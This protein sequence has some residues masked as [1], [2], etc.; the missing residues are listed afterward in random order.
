MLSMR[1]ASVWE[2]WH[3]APVAAVAQLRICAA[4][5]R[6]PASAP[7]PV[8]AQPFCPTLQRCVGHNAALCGALWTVLRASRILALLPAP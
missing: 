3:A 1:Q 5:R 6:A 7:A 8:G 2:R 4:K